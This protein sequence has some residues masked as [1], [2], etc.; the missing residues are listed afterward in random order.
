[1]ERK[2]RDLRSKARDAWRGYSDNDLSRAED[3]ASG[4][5]E[6]TDGDRNAFV[7]RR[8]EALSLVTFRSP[9]PGV[10][11]EM[12]PVIVFQTKGYNESVEKLQNMPPEKINGLIHA[13][14]KE[15]L[16]RIKKTST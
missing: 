4:K 12:M 15:F 2:I 7:Q 10:S 1:M 6:I 5:H 9:R 13:E 8:I 14:A 3:I 11:G 16:E